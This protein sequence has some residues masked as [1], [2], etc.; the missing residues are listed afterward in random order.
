MLYYSI[1]SKIHLY[2]ISVNIGPNERKKT[3]PIISL[4]SS[5]GGVGKSTTALCLAQFFEAT[6][7]TVAVL[8][9]DP[10]HPIAEWKERCDNTKISVVSEI[11]DENI[12]D[13]I[14]DS[15][16]NHQIVIIDLEGTANS[17]VSFA[18]QLSDMVI[19]PTTGSHVDTKEVAKTTKLVH[20]ASRTSGRK[21]LYK[22]LFTRQQTAVGK[23]VLLLKQALKDKG[24]PMFLNSLM[25]RDAYK[26]IFAYAETLSG[27]LDR[28]DVSN[29]MKAYNNV[30]NI[31]GELVETI[32]SGRES[33]Q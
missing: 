9:A 29:P 27:I 30:S 7:A 19:V 6:G 3:M 4:A 32:K 11:T 23:S 16:K 26:S 10:N 1:L 25:E 13:H 21:I 5:K 18:F 33:A 17:L 24:V 12:L 28:D 2:S 20:N 15:S 8:D 31:A 22:V 14:E